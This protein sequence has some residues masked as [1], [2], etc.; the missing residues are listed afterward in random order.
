MLPLLFSFYLFC[1]S[2]FNVT[3]QHSSSLAP[4][5]QVRCER[6]ARWLPTT[7]IQWP[8]QLLPP[9]GWDSMEWWA[10]WWLTPGRGSSGFTSRSH[11]PLS[12][13][14]FFF[15]FSHCHF[16][17][18]LSSVCS[19]SSS[20]VFPVTS[21]SHSPLSAPSLLHLVFSLSLPGATLLCLLPLSLLHLVFSL[22]LPGATL[23]CPS[24]SSSSSFLTVTSRNHSPL[25]LPLSLLHLVFSLSLPA[26]TLLCLLPLSLLRLIFSSLFLSCLFPPSCL[27]PSLLISLALRVT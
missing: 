11:S 24:L 10:V 18:P 15:W 21:R 26:T 6:S 19:L 4:L 20:T 8:A 17:E 25:S 7:S 12:F 23:L 1:I 13:P 22:S 9:T 16:Q 2:L 14:L 5:S 3:T 27:P